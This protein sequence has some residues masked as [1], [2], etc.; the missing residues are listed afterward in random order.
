MDKKLKDRL[1]RYNKEAE[2]AGWLWFMVTFVILNMFFIANGLPYII[3]AIIAFIVK[4]FVTGNKKDSNR[5]KSNELYKNYL[6]EYIDYSGCNQDNFNVVLNG[7]YFY[8]YHGVIKSS[9]RKVGNQIE[10]HWTD[11]IRKFSLNE[12]LDLI[13]SKSDSFDLFNKYLIQRFRQLHFAD[14]WDSF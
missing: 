4:W 5:T 2:S 12:K 8:E 6:E 3:P 13:Y 10:I 9:M 11:E 14:S 1:N 7:G